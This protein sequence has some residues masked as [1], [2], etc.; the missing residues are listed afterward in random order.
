MDD[1]GLDTNARAILGRLVNF[2]KHRALDLPSESESGKR[3][4]RA[5]K[6]LD[7]GLPTRDVA[8]ELAELRKEH[9]GLP[10]GISRKNYDE[11][12]ED[13]DGA[14]RALIRLQPEHIAPQKV[15]EFLNVKIEDPAQAARNTLLGIG[16]AALLMFAMPATIPEFSGL[17]IKIDGGTTL[18]VVVL[19]ICLYNLSAFRLEVAAALSY[20]NEAL[21]QMD[22]LARP[23]KLCRDVLSECQALFP[24]D[25]GVACAAWVE[26]ADIQL[27]AHKKRRVLGRFKRWWRF[28]LP[29]WLG[30]AAV[31]AGVVRLCV[32]VP[33]SAESDTSRAVQKLERIAASLES[34]QSR[35]AMPSG[36]RGQA[37]VLAESG[38]YM[39]DD[40]CFVD[41]IDR[42]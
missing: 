7:D 42:H 31:V 6:L 8:R 1:E 23:V 9:A 28:S 35:E 21:S 40:Y 32:G 26:Q 22:A 24:P 2:V 5:I 20:R 25:L 15:A 34:M 13:I 39:D 18:V 12:M 41:P 30:V 3:L 10:A 27:T 29:T 36:L 17:G 37:V 4:A 33:T 19:A 11:K 38:W 16:S 14:L